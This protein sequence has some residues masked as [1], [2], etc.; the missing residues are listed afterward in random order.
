[1]GKKIKTF[2][3]GSYLEY[4]RG[5]FDD[6]C[7]YLTDSTGNRRPPR[8]IDYFSTL[9]SLAGEYSSERIYSD[10]CDIYDRTGKVL[11]NTVLEYITTVASTYGANALLVNQIFSILYMAMIAE[12]QKK[13]T[14][15][16]KRIKR[17]GIYKLLIESTPA[18]EAANFM[19]GMGWRDI[20]EM[21]K[22]RG[23]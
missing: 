5:S 6:W 10:Y 15:L 21:C 11:D 23:F 1:M 7:V 12:E 22:E 3:N 20:A 16:G 14:K 18:R 17:L 13:Y 9:V 19:R 2:S 8:D 4:D